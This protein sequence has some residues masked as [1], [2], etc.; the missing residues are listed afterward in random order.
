ML[1]VGCASR[2]SV[3]SGGVVLT[4]TRFCGVSERGNSLGLLLIGGRTD[5]SQRG[6]QS[7][8]IVKR[9]Q[10]L[11]DRLASLRPTLKGLPIHALA[12]ER[13]KEA[14]HERVIITIPFP[15]HAHHDAVL[16]EQL[17]I[18][19]SGILTAAIRVMQ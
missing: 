6:M 11:K 19:G 14:L 8:S 18:V 17:P 2:L 3:S 10:V 9:L 16:R 13:A 1:F 15:A 5:I 12:F 4:L 7:L